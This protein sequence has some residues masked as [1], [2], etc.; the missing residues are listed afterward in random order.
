MGMDNWEFE[1]IVMEVNF[2]LPHEE[3]VAILKT[4]E[5]L[6]HQSPKWCVTDIPQQGTTIIVVRLYECLCTTTMQ[7]LH[8]DMMRLSLRPILFPEAVAIDQKMAGKHD[9][10]CLGALWGEKADHFLCRQDGELHLH[11]SKLSLKS[12]FLCPAVHYMR[13]WNPIPEIEV[14]ATL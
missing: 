4:D 6:I 11:H 2:G 8:T 7:K 3:L 5:A 1:R 14:S 13:D 10:I 12:K 9:W